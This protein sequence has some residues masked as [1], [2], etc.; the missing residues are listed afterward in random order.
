MKKL[1]QKLVDGEEIVESVCKIVH[2]CKKQRLSRLE[3]LQVANRIQVMMIHRMG[4]E[5]QWLLDK[6]KVKNYGYE[7]KCKCTYVLL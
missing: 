7:L 1:D 3:K 2:W 6:N 5:Y 4:R